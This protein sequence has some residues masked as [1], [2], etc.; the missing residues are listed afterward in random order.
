[1]VRPERRASE[2]QRD[3][4]VS[5]ATSVRREWSDLQV[6]RA[7]LDQSVPR[8]HRVFQ[9]QL[10]LPDRAVSPGHAVRSAR[11]AIPVPRVHREI[12][13]RPVWM[14]LRC[15]DP[16][17]QSDRRDQWVRRVA[18]VGTP[19][20][21]VL[22]EQRARPEPQ[23]QQGRLGPRAQM[24]ASPVPQG[25]PALL[26]PLGQRVL[27]VQLVRRERPAPTR[28][29]PDRPAKQD[30][31]DLPAQLARPVQL[32]Q[33]AH[34]APWVR[35]AQ[36]ATRA[37]QVTPVPL[38]TRGPPEPMAQLAVQVRPGQPEPQV[39]RALRVRLEP[40][41]LPVAPVLLVQQGQPAARARQDRQAHAVRSAAT[42]CR[43]TSTRARRTL[44]PARA[45]SG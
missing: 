29:L 26:V 43:G 35:Q 45:S 19:V 40:L 36:P 42:A 9:A 33:P 38:A 32:A 44:I 21:L 16:E 25:L 7:I 31:R 18:A 14:A 24:P 22:L 37:T 2:G 5:R 23:D 30:P 6:P 4:R 12:P 39:L 13:V 34:P 1:M 15:G 11:P 20:R 17:V 27:P 28:A 3:R 41:G 10:V 8:V